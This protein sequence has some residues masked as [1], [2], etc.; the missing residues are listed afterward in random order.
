MTKPRN[1]FRWSTATACALLLLGSATMI[2][3]AATYVRLVRLRVE[4]TDACSRIEATSRSRVELVA[5]LIESAN[6]FACLGTARL[7]ELRKAAERAA[8][9]VLLGHVL[10]EPRSYQDFRRNQ[11]ELSTELSEIW[12]AVTADPRTGPL[13]ILGDFRW[14][15]DRS[16]V[17]L[18]DGFDGLD[19]RIE[20]YRAATASFSGSAVAR[21]TG[22]GSPRPRS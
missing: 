16:D 1:R 19:R 22:L 6:A 3:G 18:A 11:S 5:G 21:I 2:W 20:A 15:L 13:V 17:L 7:A 4:V 9:G 8:P 12:P 10:E 14:R